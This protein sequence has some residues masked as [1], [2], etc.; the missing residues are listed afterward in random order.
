MYKKY[1]KLITLEGYTV[2]KENLSKS[3][4]NQ[5]KKDLTIQPISL[6]ANN[7]V[8]SKIYHYLEDEDKIT[9]PV[10]YGKDKLGPCKILSHLKHPQE[11]S[12]TFNGTLK[13]E[14]EKPYDIMLNHIK[15]EKRG[16]FCASTGVGKCLGL[17]TPILMFDGTIKM[18]QDLKV[19]DL[20]MGDDSTPRKVL[21]LAR[22]EDQMY[23][24]IPIKGDKYTVNEEHILVLKI[25]GKPSIKEDKRRK[26]WYVKWFENNKYNCITFKE[27]KEGLK[28]L[29]NVKNQEIMEISVKEYLKLSKSVKHVLKWYRTSIDFPEKELDFDPYII[30][31]WLGDGDSR[32]TC[33]T[34]QDSAILKYIANNL[35]K[36]KCYLKYNG[37]PRDPYCYRINGWKRDNKFLTALVNNNLI[38]NKHIP[39]IYKCN[40]R[41]NRLKLLAGLLDSDGSL[42]KDKCSFSFIQKSERL[43]DDVI[44]LCRSLGFACYKLK[45][46]K[47][48]WYKDEYKEGDYFRITI[49][50]DT[51]QIPTLCPRKKANSRKQIKNVLVSGFKVVKTKRDNYYGFTLDR[52]NRFV[53][54]DFTVSHNT[55]L[56]LKLISDLGLKTLVISASVNQIDLLK[57]WESQINKFLPDTKIGLIQGKTTN[58]QNKDVI[59]ST[60]SSLSRKNYDKDVFKDVGFVII[61]ECFAPWQKIRTNNGL[62]TIYQI[63]IQ[64]INNIPVYVQAYDVQN[65][66]VVS[67]LVTYAWEKKSTRGLIRIEFDC[68]TYI[69]CTPNH[70]FLTINGK[71]KKAQDLT[72]SDI[73]LHIDTNNLISPVSFKNKYKYMVEST[74]YDLEVEIDHNYI[75]DCGIVAH[76]CH[77]ISSNTHSQVLFKIGGI[78]HILGLSA[79]PERQDGLTQI[80]K[81]WI[82]D[83]FHSFKRTIEGL[84]PRVLTLELLSNEYKEHFINIGFKTQICFTKMITDLINIKK[85]NDLIVDLVI[86]MAKQKRQI[87]LVSERIEHIKIL[88]SILHTKNVDFS[89]S[90]YIG[91]SM[92]EEEKKKAMKCQVILA[93][94]QSFGEGIDKSTLD[95]LILSTPKKYIAENKSKKIYASISFVQLIGRIFRQKHI[96]RNPLI[97][98]IWDS[99]SVFKAQGYTRQRYYKDN[100]NNASLKKVKIDLESHKKLQTSWFNFKEKESVIEEKETSLLLED[101]ILLDD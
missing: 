93:T 94:L 35:Q 20:L 101:L 34:N 14:Q 47:G 46:K 30:G 27:K 31:I 69:D 15:N 80:L 23:D 57:Q 48:C 89:Y 74:V 36:Y 17:N 68:N 70:E 99:F 64:T 66:K 100:L 90:S 7:P 5:I 78:Q 67:R 43:V 39:H 84:N 87:L 60:I 65:K 4:I 52:N 6:N 59:L 98:D 97:I 91:T 29:K 37:T 54:G 40:S 82:G 28:Y 92:K 2:S 95:T 55:V 21:S 83:I 8:I 75:L 25:S 81:W 71:W 76:N 45:C 22:G 38:M 44:Y 41:E 85:R 13:K 18:V 56:A 58:Y 16:I 32:T 72:Y 3:D 24:I 10:K 51:D 49:N 53:L 12:I 62:L 86:H 19:G 73:F 96:Q 77:H 79:T 50:G 26:T 11:I 61:D 33:I 9:V 63:Y 88:E 1:P 42:C